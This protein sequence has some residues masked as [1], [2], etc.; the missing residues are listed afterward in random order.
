MTKMTPCYFKQSWA[1]SPRLGWT[2]SYDDALPHFLAAAFA[3]LP[4]G[5]QLTHGH[6][7]K[8]PALILPPGRRNC[9]MA[10]EGATRATITL[11]LVLREKTRTD[12]EG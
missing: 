9:S 2:Q 5:N 7:I 12:K 11:S 1:F 4:W 10:L 3:S 8:A 6:T